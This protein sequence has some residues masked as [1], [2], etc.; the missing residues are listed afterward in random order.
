MDA[1][2]LGKSRESGA[3]MAR[4]LIVTN[5]IDVRTVLEIHLRSAEHTVLSC[6]AN[7]QALAVLRV[8]RH[9][10]VV[11]LHSSLTA[12]DSIAVL[13]LLDGAGTASYLARHHYVVLGAMPR[14]LHPAQQDLCTRLRA[15]ALDLPFDL[16]DLEA[17]VEHAEHE[18]AS[19]V[20]LATSS[21]A[22][23]RV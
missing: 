5:D 4:I 13:Q 14:A 15:N 3:T 21:S 16:I 10:L 22:E 2:R 12:A 9:P 7:G 11:L 19:R 6:P 20:T 1:R 8:S 18:L 23:D 17:A